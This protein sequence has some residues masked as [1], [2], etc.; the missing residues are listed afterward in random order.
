MGNTEYDTVG[1]LTTGVNIGVPLG[2]NFIVNLTTYRTDNFDSDSDYWQ[3]GGTASYLVSD[4][5][6]VVFGI[7]TVTG[8]F[9]LK[10]LFTTYITSF[11]DTF[12]K[13]SRKVLSCF[14]S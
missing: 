3:I 13:S 2:N 9:T 8:L 6:E 1:I 11:I 14:I 4:I 5:F 12:C 7:T 10:Y